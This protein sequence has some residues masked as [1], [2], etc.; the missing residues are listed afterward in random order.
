MYLISQLVRL[1]GLFGV[2]VS[3][4]LKIILNKHCFAICVIVLMLMSCS[5][6]INAKIRFN[7]NYNFQQIKSY[8]LFSRSSSFAEIQNLTD[9]TRNTV[10]MTIEQMFDQQ[11]FVYQEVE[12]ADVIIS[13]Y[14]IDNNYQELKQYN[15][16]V[17]Y[18]L[19]CLRGGENYTTRPWLNIP[20]HLIIDIL[21]GQSQSSVWRSVHPL[22]IQ[23]ADN[24]QEKKTKMNQ[25]IGLMLNQFP[26]NI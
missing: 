19:P 10:E 25:T 15:N 3:F 14:L 8:G 1:A 5:Q 11:G 4:K 21:D 20:G 16:K 22:Q 18:C 2:D 6:Q 17:K 24:S 26:N 9:A 23:G 13:Y 12:Q 7:P